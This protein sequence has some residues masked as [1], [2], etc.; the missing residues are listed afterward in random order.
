MN[1]SEHEKNFILKHSEESFPNECGGI[2][3][4]NSVHRCHNFSSSPE[5][6]CVISRDEANEK[7]GG[8][9]IKALYH[10]HVNDNDDF[11]WEDKALSEEFG[12]KL[13]LC[14]VTKK[15]FKCYKPNGFIAPFV[16][17]KWIQGVFTC[18]SI[19]EDYYK[20]YF[21]IEIIV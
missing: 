13:V 15:L 11:S 4:E 7:A 5:E 10:S 2:I 8:L 3:L 20:K 1:L 16:G 12:I 21:N 9:E 19:I 17:R 6:S 14:S 18:I